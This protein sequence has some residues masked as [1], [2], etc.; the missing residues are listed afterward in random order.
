[1][2][3]QATIRQDPAIASEDQCLQGFDG[4]SVA[5]FLPDF[6]PDFPGYSEASVFNAAMISFIISGETRCGSWR[7]R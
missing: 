7:H 1:M 3:D 4:M 5:G 2:Q 6:L